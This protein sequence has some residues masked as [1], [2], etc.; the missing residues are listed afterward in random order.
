MIPKLIRAALEGERL[1]LAALEDAIHAI[2]LCAGRVHNRRID[3]H[4]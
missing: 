3:I 2:V 4:K 1:D